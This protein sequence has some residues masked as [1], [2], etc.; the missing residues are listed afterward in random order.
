MNFGIVYGISD[1]SLAQDLKISRYEAR[2]YIDSYLSKY[3]GV[4]KYM[5]DIV[6]KAKKE[7]L[8]QPFSDA[9][10]TFLNSNQKPQHP[11]IW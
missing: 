10:D 8:Y 6:E 5:K 1:F 2:Q 11:L 7:A 3:S 4:S 9:G